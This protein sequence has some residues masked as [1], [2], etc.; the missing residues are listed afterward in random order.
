MWEWYRID[1]K[2]QFN[3]FYDNMSKGKKFYNEWNK[4]D[5]LFALWIGNNDIINLYKKNVTSEID[6]ITD[7]L[8]DTIEKMYIV[9]ARN[10]LILKIF[11]KNYIINKNK[12]YLKND[13]LRFNNNIITKSKI[14]FEKYPD[15]NLIIYNTPDKLEEVISNCNAYK[16]KDCVNNWDKNKDIKEFFWVNSHIS[17]PGNKILAQDINDLLDSLNK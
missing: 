2:G 16:F 8:F 14:L 12:S 10:I 1:L 6:E 11:Q 5:S 9:G 7:N 4:K 13:I 15:I 17:D 3:Y